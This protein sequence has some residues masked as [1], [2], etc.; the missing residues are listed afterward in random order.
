MRVLGV[1]DARV[2]H[3]ATELSVK[4]LAGG[5]SAERTKEHHFSGTPR[6]CHRSPAPCVCWWPPVFPFFFSPAVGT[7]ARMCVF[8]IPMVEKGGDQGS[9]IMGSPRGTSPQDCHHCHL[10]PLLMATK[11]TS[12]PYGFQGPRSRSPLANLL[13]AV[14]AACCSVGL[15]DWARP[16]GHLELCWALKTALV[17]VQSKGIAPL[18]A[19]KPRFEWSKPMC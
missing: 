8:L 15:W 7:T 13:M 3:G 10:L 14:L 9:K 16:E 19:P 5:F 4:G 6:V 1:R 2:A 17:T 11:A 12:A 18:P